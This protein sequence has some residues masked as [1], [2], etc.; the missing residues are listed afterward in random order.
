ML[1]NLDL[2][3]KII[4]SVFVHITLIFIIFTF[5]VGWICKL[6][7]W[8]FGFL[9]NSIDEFYIISSYILTSGY[10]KGYFQENIPIWYPVFWIFEYAWIS[11]RKTQ[12]IKQN[13]MQEEV[14]MLKPNVQDGFLFW[15]QWD[16]V[17]WNMGK[18]SSSY[19]RSVFFFLT[20]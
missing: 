4:N 3:L 7:L 9:L 10:A 13:F 8:S 16:D 12:K 14:Q 11:R 2:R 19:V 20:T 18:R 1:I 17:V 6:C 15:K 5:N